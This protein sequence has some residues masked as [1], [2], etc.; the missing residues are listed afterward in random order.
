MKERE[1]IVFSIA[2]DNARVTGC[3]VSRPILDTE[4]YGIAYFSIAAGTDISA[5]TYGYPKLLLVHEGDMT[6]YTSGGVELILAE[7]CG[8]ATPVNV[9]VGMKSKTGAVYTE[10]R[11]KEDTV[12]MNQVLKDGTVFRLAELLPYQEGRIVNMDLISDSKLK[13]VVMSFDEGTGLSEHA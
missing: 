6:V 4:D 9:P 10:L 12:M 1:G 13:F 5:E 8:I 11:L 7:G 3:T 2:R